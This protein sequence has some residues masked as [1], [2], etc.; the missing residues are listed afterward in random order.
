MQVDTGEDYYVAGKMLRTRLDKETEESVEE[1]TSIATLEIG[2]DMYKSNENRILFGYESAKITMTSENEGEEVKYGEEINYKITIKNTGRTNVEDTKYAGIVVDL[3]DLLPEGIDPISV[4][5]DN[6]E[7]KIII[8]EDES[9][10]VLDEFIK[11]DP[12]TENIEG[13]MVED[14]EGNDLYNFNIQFVIPYKESVTIE[15]KT[16]AGFVYE[17]TKVENKA[18]V[19]GEYIQTK[20]SNMISHTIL[21]YNYEEKE[22][23]GNPENPDPVD[24]DN[25]ENPE[26]PDKPDDPNKPKNKGKIEKNMKS[27]KKKF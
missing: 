11:K 2:E 13:I 22:E 20:N 10:D 4:T 15:V 21:P 5:Y 6:W 27:K 14:E 25:P 23:P 17:K 19:T 12:V 9:C 3:K 1:L 7:Q 16:K 8:Y 18:T 26:N 24:P